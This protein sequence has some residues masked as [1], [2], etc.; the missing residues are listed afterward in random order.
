MRIFLYLLIVLIFASCG[1]G[2][3]SGLTSTDSSADS[4]SS[5]T[6]T[7]DDST[8]YTNPDKTVLEDDEFSSNQWHRTQLS[9]D[10]LNENYTGYNS[11]TPIIVQ[12]VD[13]GVEIDHEDLTDNISSSGSYNEETTLSDPSPEEGSTHGTSVAGIIAAVGYNNIGLKGVAPAAQ[14][15]GYKFT[16]DSDGNL[17]SNADMETAWLTGEIANNIAISNNSWGHCEYNDTDYEDILEQGSNLLRDGK[18]RLYVFAAG[19]EREG[20]I[21]SCNSPNPATANTS[22]LTNN[23]YAITVAAVGSDNKYSYYSSP[24]ANVLVSGYSDEIGTTVPEGTST[25]ATTW[26]GDT[27]RN[28]TNIFNGTSAAAPFVSGALALVLEACPDLTYRDIKYLIAN[29]STKIDTSNDSWVSN[30]A[31]YSHS[32]DY[33]FGLINPQAMITE[34][35]SSGYT[36]LGAKQ[37]R[38]TTDTF[39]STISG[40]HIPLTETLTVQNAD[41]LIVEWVG[42]TITTNY[43]F[44]GNLEIKLT[45][46]S[47]TESKL[48]HF[49]NN[50]GTGKRFFENGFRLSSQAFMGENSAG[51]WTIEITSNIFA[52]EAL[53]G[54]S[55]EVVGH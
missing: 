41:D 17:T 3:G 14:L 20:D 13:D 51:V 1:G 5:Q 46:P 28:Y 52:T 40:P 35:T 31:G 39:S 44:P 48:L 34:C 53:S 42:L 30:A 27:Y 19:N 37:T 10:T 33:G 12:V 36:L 21:T 38:T 32:N 9:L 26:S 47:G 25:S 43:Q 18:G 4:S 8:I 2:G 22:Y 55:L 23:Q 29:Y 49:N 7:R 45:S 11:G 15:V 54:L 6:Q 50:L 16:T 24:G